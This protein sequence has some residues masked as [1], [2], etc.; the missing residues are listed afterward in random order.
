[1]KTNVKKPTR[2]QLLLRITIIVFIVYNCAWFA[3][4]WQYA[5]LCTDEYIYAG[6][7]SYYRDDPPYTF[8][9][10]TPDYLS[11]TGNYAIT[12]EDGSCLLIWPNTFTSCYIYGISLPYN[13]SMC[14]CYIDRNACYQRSEKMVISEEEEQ[15]IEQLLSERKMFLETML[16]EADVEWI[17]KK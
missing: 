8:S 10:K 12:I 3:N 2:K 1:M 9:I 6:H 11:F 7:G 5:K 14:N 16:D 17:A 15:I 4:W 13:D